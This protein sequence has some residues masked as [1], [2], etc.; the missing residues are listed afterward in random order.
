[1]DTVEISVGELRLRVL[2]ANANDEPWNLRRKTIEEKQSPLYPLIRAE[3][4]S[5]GST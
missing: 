4:A 1:M 3:M 5:A 2:A